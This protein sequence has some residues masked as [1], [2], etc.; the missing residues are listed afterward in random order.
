MP[1][2]MERKVMLSEGMEEEA[3]SEED[4]EGEKPRVGIV[5]FAHKDSLLI[6]N[7]DTSTFPSIKSSYLQV[8]E[9]INP[10]SMLDDIMGPLVEHP[11]LRKSN[12]EMMKRGGL[13][14]IIA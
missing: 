5:G 13:P 9:H 12:E 14:V 1:M 11:K 6:T 7:R 3:E 10:R 8:V 2:Y 4:E